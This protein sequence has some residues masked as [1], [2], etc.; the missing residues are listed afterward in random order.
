MK[1]ILFGSAAAICAVVGFSSFKGQTIK[2]YWFFVDEETPTSVSP[3]VGASNDGNPISGTIFVTPLST[4]VTPVTE[5]NTG[6]GWAGSFYCKIAVATS[7]TF[8]FSGQRFL[9]T[10]N[11]L[12]VAIQAD[13]TRFLPE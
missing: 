5:D 4:S 11:N 6:C 7:D 2:F 12:P 1:R 3:T 9:N 10:V 13:Y 8:T